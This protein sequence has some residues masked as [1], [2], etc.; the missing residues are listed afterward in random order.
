MPLSSR[1]AEVLP[2]GHHGFIHGVSSSPPGSSAE[3]LVTLKIMLSSS[4]RC[5]QVPRSQGL[6]ALA[7]S[8]ACAWQLRC[9][10]KQEQHA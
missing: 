6:K 10:A 8:H 2:P 7:K 1:G 4:P 5:C 9:T 3:M